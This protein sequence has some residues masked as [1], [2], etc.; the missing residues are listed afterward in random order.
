MNILGIFLVNFSCL[1][2]IKFNLS[3]E[4]LNE[5]PVPESFNFGFKLEFLL[6]FIE[7]FPKLDTVLKSVKKFFATCM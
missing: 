1:S 2:E 3:I 6:L 4:T 7:K 5:S